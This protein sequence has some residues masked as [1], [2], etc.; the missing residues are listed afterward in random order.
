MTPG[1]SRMKAVL[2]DRDGVIN[3]LVYHENVGV[4]DSPFNVSQFELLPRVPEAIGVL[5]N[6][7]LKIAIVSNQPGI[8]KGHLKLDTLKS[9]ERIM[10]KEIRSAGGRIDSIN[11]CL[12]HPEAKIAE[13]RKKCEC[14]KPAIG[15]LRQASENLGVSLEECYMV[16]D[17]IPDI[18]AG[19]RAGCRNIFIGRW[20]CEICQFTEDPQARP[21]LVAK[22]LWEA[23][24]L[25]KLE[26]NEIA[27]SDSWAS[28]T[29]DPATILAKRL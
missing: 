5:A 2:L 25:I 3:A 17:G 9:F 21:A 7:G 26:M 1:T 28:K 29:E 8:G 23:S 19:C 10:L 14:R 24:Q 18:L 12:H 6:L 15:L 22:D 27:A 11:Y 13:Y 16:G 20:K 4:I